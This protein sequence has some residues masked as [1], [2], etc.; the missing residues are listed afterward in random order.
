MKQTAAHLSRSQLLSA[1]A[2]APVDAAAVTAAAAAVANSI[3][4]QRHATTRILAAGAALASAV[5][6]GGRSVDA[7]V[8]VG[9]ASEGKVRG[10]RLAAAGGPVGVTHRLACDSRR[11]R[12]EV[13][14]WTVALGDEAAEAAPGLT[15]LQAV[16]VSTIRGELGHDFIVLTQAGD[17]LVV[18]AV[19]FLK[20][21]PSAMSRCRCGS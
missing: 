11:R 17:V 2:A 15:A 3:H 18:R 9:D 10:G 4:A 8:S 12:W 13:Q 21:N 20:Q 14:V 1:A 7:V 5:A 19:D 6:S 16:S